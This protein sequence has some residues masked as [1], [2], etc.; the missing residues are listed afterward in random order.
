MQNR[1]VQLNPKPAR[2]GFTLIELLVVI[3]IIATLMALVLPAI[4]NAR[5]AAR[6]LECKN[7]LKNI[8]LAAHNFASAKKRFPPLGVWTG[9]PIAPLGLRS[10]VVELLPFMDRRD[11][12]DRWDNLSQ[13]NVGA[14]S[15]ASASGSV[16]NKTYVKVL[17]CPDDQTAVG[18][19][20]ALSYVA[21]NGYL[22]NDTT[23][24]VQNRWTTGVLNWNNGA[25]ADVGANS[26]PGYV[27][28]DKA[29]ADAHRD[30]G[31]FWADYGS[32]SYLDAD[33]VSREQQKNSHSVDGIYDGGS[34]TILFT[35]NINAGGSGG[36]ANPSWSNVGFVYVV[37]TA[38]LVPLDTAIG[39]P[40]VTDNSYRYPQ[41]GINAATSKTDNLL[42]RL[43]SGPEATSTLI[44]AAAP[45]SA[46][47]GG[48]NIGYADGSVGFISD[49]INT[50]VYA[51][52]ISPGGA[53]RRDTS[54]IPSQDPLGDN[55]Y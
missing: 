17:A 10:W 33:N 54:A 39:K 24:T 51:S 35:E 15:T 13:W 34:Q 22:V 26:F 9:T 50:T 14:N 8:T 29:D 5:A 31:V 46:H 37:A 53:R 40:A 28:I 25:T 38:S 18:A 45:N 44:F 36:W 2:R 3:S 49:N 47:P 23:G 20:G 16:L 41:P 19:N 52:L 12:S 6:T 7:N 30:T 27:D 21:N 1:R 42:N 43:K 11:I 48:V 32:A 4:Q 55:S